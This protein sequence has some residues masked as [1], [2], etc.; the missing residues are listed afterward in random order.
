L[1][2]ATFTAD[3][4]TR[5]GLACESG[6]IDL[7]AAAP[8]LAEDIC[9]FLGQ[10]PEAMELARSITASGAPSIEPAQ[11]RLHA[12]V[13]RPPKILGIGLNYKDHIQE[14]GRAAP[15]V[16]VVFNKQSTAV[17]GTGSPIYRPQESF[18][19]DY[20]GELAFVIGERCRRVPK[21]RAAEVIA[22]YTVCN[23]VSVRDWQR[24]SP[25]MTMG[26][27]RPG[28]RNASKRRDPAVV[29]HSPFAVRLLRVS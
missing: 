2:L 29:E 20:E 21:R 11:F 1:K 12:P 23:D 15:E 8:E 3:G 22:G 16:P 9:E 26:T 27:A 4:S 5:I 17:T 28:H 6:M 7:R 10:G 25:T 13:L 18:H 19:L 14:T 24:R